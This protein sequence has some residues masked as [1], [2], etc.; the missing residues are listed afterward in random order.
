MIDA[1]IIL[2]PLPGCIGDVSLV[3]CVVGEVVV[4]VVVNAPAAQT[5]NK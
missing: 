1:Y 4:T 2:S 3:E 5:I